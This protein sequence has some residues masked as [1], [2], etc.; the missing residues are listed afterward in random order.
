MIDTLKTEGRKYSLIH[1]KDK[2]DKNKEIEKQ[3]QI[4]KIKEVF[5][6]NDIKDNNKDNDE[7]NKQLYNLNFG[8]K[9]IESFQ[10]FFLF[11][12]SI[13]S[14][15]YEPEFQKKKKKIFSS[16]KNIKYIDKNNINK[17]NQRDNLENKTERQTTQKNNIISEKDKKNNFNEDILNVTQ[18]QMKIFDDEVNKLYNNHKNDLKLKIFQINH[19]YLQNIKLINNNI[20]STTSSMTKEQRIF[21]IIQKQKLILK[22]IQENNNSKNNSSISR[23]I[24]DSISHSTE[25][26]NNKLNKYLFNKSSKKNLIQLTIDNNQNIFDNKSTTEKSKNNSTEKI[27]LT[28]RKNIDYKPYTLVQYK[29]KYEKNNLKILGG[30]GANLG[31]EEWNKRQRLF[32]RKKRY[33]DFIKNDE[34][35]YHF[36]KKKI[37]KNINKK[38]EYVKKEFDDSNHDYKY[39][40]FKTE[41]NIINNNKELKLPLISQRN[42]SIQRIK[43]KRNKNKNKNNQ[44]LNINQEHELEGSEKD[45]K[46]L[47]KQ[48]EEYNE[49]LK[50]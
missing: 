19:P 20:E 9:N 42:K 45:L 1:F 47:I 11:K 17:D 6:D 32:E 3:I 25:N 26:K 5:K 40:I 4:E 13:E 23:N 15:K 12:N 24:N 28:K 36:N 29:N 35:F 50:L 31:G 43:L 38:K 21:P 16:K 41:N 46:Q 2:F 27:N 34:E 8:S 18:D 10:N 30:L 39:K 14:E 48:Y 49:K 22:K 33:S 37:I 44:I 7:Y